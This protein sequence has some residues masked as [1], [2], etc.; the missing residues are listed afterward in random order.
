MKIFLLSAALSLLAAT[1]IQATPVAYNINF[2]MNVG[3]VAPTSGMFT[4]DAAVPNFTNFIV[5]WNGNSY[6]LTS[7]ANN[8]FFL[9]GSP[10]CLSGAT[11]AAASF[12][13]L[14][15][16]LCPADSTDWVGSMASSPSA[17]QFYFRHADAGG[18][19]QVQGAG[20]GGADAL[21]QGTWTITSAGI[22]EP[23]TFVLTAVAGALLALTRRRPSI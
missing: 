2:I 13:L 9:G 22:P 3:I 1:A 17:S 7:A 8:P 5:Q 19:M 11:G 14:S 23:S 16:T 12:G 4:Y 6:D 21:S 18:F 20:P 15:Q 10:S